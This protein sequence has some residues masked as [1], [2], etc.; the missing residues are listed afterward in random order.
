MCVCA[1]ANLSFLFSLN[2]GDWHAWKIFRILY[3]GN[4][5]FGFQFFAFLQTKHVLKRDLL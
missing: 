5:F 1:K 2:L 4:N 3:K